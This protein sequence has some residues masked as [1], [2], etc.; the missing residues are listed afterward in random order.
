MI[1][2]PPDYES[3]ALTNWAIGPKNR[4]VL[5]GGKTNENQVQ[6]HQWSGL[7]CCWATT[8]A[9]LAQEG[10]FGNRTTFI[11]A[12]KKATGQNPSVFFALSEGSDD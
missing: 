11:R 12:V 4:I 8:L 3:G 1:L 7:T 6:L 2:R 5:S 10:G 9:G